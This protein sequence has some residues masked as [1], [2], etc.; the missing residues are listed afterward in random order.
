MAA[1]LPTP[2]ERARKNLQSIFRALSS[3]GQARLAEAMNVSE[4][5][6]SRWKTEQAEHCARALSA[7]GLKVVPIEMRCFDP[8]KIDAI[9]QL[10]KAHRAEIEGADR[11]AWDE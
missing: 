2:D 11:L 3:V 9:L 7:L 6:V 4:A 8:K 10:A 5:S 1:V